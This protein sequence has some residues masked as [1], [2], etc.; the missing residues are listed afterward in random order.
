[1]E[2]GRWE[3][4]DGRWEVGDGKRE[5]NHERQR[6]SLVKPGVGP[7]AEVPPR[8]TRRRSPTPKRVASVGPDPGHR[9]THPAGPRQ[10]ASGLDSW[11]PALPG[12][13]TPLSRQP[14]ALRGNRVAVDAALHGP[15]PTGPPTHRPTDPPTHRPTDPPTHRPTDLPT[16]RP[17]AASATRSRGC[18]RTSPRARRVRWHREFPD[19]P[20]VR[21][22]A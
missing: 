21:S 13:A 10:P 18:G 20:P 12:V 3:M 1:M 7:T 16:T 5:A 11:N 15:R 4:G 17:P 2:G 14:R 9:V 19:A 22:R 6:R 8:V